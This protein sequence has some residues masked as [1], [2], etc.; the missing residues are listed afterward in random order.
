MSLVSLGYDE[1]MPLNHS[2]KLSVIWKI[3]PS[4]FRQALSAKWAYPWH[5]KNKVNFEFGLKLQAQQIIMLL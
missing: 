1:M 4:K 2:I 5:V 3:L